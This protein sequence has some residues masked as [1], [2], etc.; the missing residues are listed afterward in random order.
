METATLRSLRSRLNVLQYTRGERLFYRSVIIS[1]LWHPLTEYLEKKKNRAHK[2]KK[3]NL[4]LA[5]IKKTNKLHCN[6]QEETSI[7]DTCNY[8]R[9]IISFVR[10][11]IDEIL[12]RRKGNG[13]H[14][15]V[16]EK[17]WEKSRGEERRHS[18][19]MRASN[20]Y[21]PSSSADQSPW[22]LCRV[23]FVFTHPIP[24]HL[25]AQGGGGYDY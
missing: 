17:S 2:K 12:Q 24:V 15:R 21:Q 7:Y 23:R 4:S 19:W 1:Q 10:R 6:R 8:K 11:S 22:E 25:R 9:V 13:C 3:K 16:N 5:T 20:R 18:A 14:I